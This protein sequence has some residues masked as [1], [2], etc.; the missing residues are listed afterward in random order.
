MSNNGAQQ[1]EHD[2][3]N[4]P[5]HDRSQHQRP[6]CDDEGEDTQRHSRQHEGGPTSRVTFRM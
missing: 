5:V 2:E 6:D 1:M 4:Q 3:L